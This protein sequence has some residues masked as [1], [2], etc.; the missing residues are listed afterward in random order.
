V[1]DWPAD[2]P[3]AM[4][5][6]VLAL[7]ERA[8][9]EC[10]EAARSQIAARMGGHSELPLN[11]LNELYL[12]APAPLRRE[13]LMRNELE[14]GDDAADAAVDGETLLLVARNGTRDFAGALS[15][16]AAI[17]RTTAEAILS[18]ASGEAL[19]VLCRGAGLDRA[20]FSAVAVLRGARELPL[21]V[22]DTVAE[23]AAHRLLRYWRAH[24]E[25]P[26]AGHVRA[27]E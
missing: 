11:L 2:Y 20:T 3:E 25:H 21:S 27:A 1:L 7:L 22:F 24:G 15:E 5:D 10:D 18:D 9:R 14:S 13:I 23:H 19:A 8:A 16:A 26:L 6:P 4:R 17:P 12:A